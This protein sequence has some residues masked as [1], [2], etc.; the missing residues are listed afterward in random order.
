MNNDER[1]PKAGRADPGVL[2]P[3]VEAALADALVPVERPPAHRAALRERVLQRA[4][5]PRMITIPADDAGWSEVMPKVRAKLAY[6]D[7]TA[8]SYLVRL[9][10]GARVP[11]HDHPDVEECVVLQGEVR[12]LGGSTLRAGDYECAPR[13][14]HHSELVSATGAL[15][16]LRYARPLDQYIRA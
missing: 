10:P 9:E 15:L 1:L 5:A 3:E 13:G 7:G 6:T 11:A 12:Y 8:Q 14:A 4:R 2:P 16:F